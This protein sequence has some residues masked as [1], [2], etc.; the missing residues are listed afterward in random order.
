MFTF[1]A[2]LTL[3]LRNVLLY[4]EDAATVIFHTFIMICYVTPFLGAYISDAVIGKFKYVVI[5]IMHTFHHVRRLWTQ[6][7]TYLTL[8]LYI[9]FM[10]DYFRTIFYFSIIHAMG[11]VILSIAAFK[12][13][14]FPAV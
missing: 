10:I 9:L 11:N 4:N 14:P 2:I 5:I 3:Y 12:N 1:T 6:M 7:Q 8:L 13:P